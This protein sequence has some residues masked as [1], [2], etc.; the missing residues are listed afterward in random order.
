MLQFYSW[1][2]PLAM[3][4]DW[5]L[6][7]MAIL[8]YS[9]LINYGWMSIILWNSNHLSNGT[10]SQFPKIT[11]VALNALFLLPNMSFFFYCLMS[12]ELIHSHSERRHAAP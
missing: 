2:T 12:N 1:L 3:L 8:Q 9:N 11:P 5:N 4:Q 7:T 10:K 6:T